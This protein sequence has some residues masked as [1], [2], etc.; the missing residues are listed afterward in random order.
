MDTVGG[1]KNKKK[2]DGEKEKVAS[3]EEEEEALRKDVEDLKSWVCTYF[4]YVSSPDNFA[5]NSQKKWVCVYIFFISSLCPKFS[6]RN[7]YIYIKFYSFCF[8]TI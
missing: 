3:K 1:G 5:L 4:F 8:F 7:G 6:K 2:A